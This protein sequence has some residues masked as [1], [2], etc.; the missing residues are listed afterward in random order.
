MKRMLYILLIFI[1]ILFVGC[2]KGEAL[3]TDTLIDQDLNNVDSDRINEY[4]IEVVLDDVNKSFEGKQQTVYVNNT[5]IALEELYFHIYPNAFKSLENA[6]ILFNYKYDDPSIYKGGY[7]DLLEVSSS[8]KDLDYLILGEDETLLNI[9]L[10]KP[11][12]PNETIEVNFKY[13]VKLPSSKDRFGYGDRVFNF[14][15]WYPI[16]CVY[17][18]EGWNLEPYYELGDPFYSDISNYK[19]EITLNKDIV[20]ATSGNIL[21]EDINKD[22]KTYQIEGR[23]IRDFAWVASKE[24]KIKETTVDNTIVKLYYLDTKN[25]TIRQSLKVSADAIRIFNNKFGI[26]P[27]GKYSIVMTEFSS[28]MEYPGIVFI[29]NDYFTYGMKDMLEKVIVHET[30]HQ[31]WYGLVGSNQVKEAWLDEALTTYSEVIYFEEIYGEEKGKEYFNKNIRDGY[32]Y[33]QMY[34]GSNQIVNKHLMEFSGWNDYGILV[35]T[36][37]AMFF[38]QIRKNYDEE[39]LNI[40]LK[41]YFNKYKYYNATTDGLIEIC[42]RVTGDDFSQLVNMW[43]N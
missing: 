16:A 23:L 11:L 4:I 32:D 24:F 29:S 8:D 14:G 9:K 26:Y 42:E 28:G 25:T 17:D 40:I 31:W 5:N 37:G 10:D 36:K 6:P 18:K 13:R 1:V 2:E 22:K 39:T 41:E 21:T 7:I 20:V 43:I 19:V 33:G 30:A 15:N 3:S 35:Y 12:E 34:L 38:D 27:Y